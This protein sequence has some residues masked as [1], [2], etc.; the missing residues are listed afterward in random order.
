VQLWEE[1]F[2]L[3]R[4]SVFTALLAFSFLASSAT[5]QQP[6]YLNTKLSPQERAHDLVG[7]MTLDEKAA[8]LEDS[9]AEV[10]EY[11]N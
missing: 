11:Q 7:R 8:Q 2:M 3:L 5:S 10:V 9:V 1:R 6:D 4:R